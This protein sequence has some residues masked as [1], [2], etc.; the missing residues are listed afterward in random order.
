MGES[1][2]SCE[3]GTTCVRHLKENGLRE[4]RARGKSSWG[5]LGA[6]YRG[7]ASVQR[8]GRDRGWETVTPQGFL[9][10][11]SFYLKCSGNKATE[12]FKGNKILIPF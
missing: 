5:I 2:G 6:E 8:W 9:K 4:R 12:G 7:R 1:G 10:G 11:L 3:G